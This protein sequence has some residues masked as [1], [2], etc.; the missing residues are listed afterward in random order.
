[1]SNERALGRRSSGLLLLKQR[2]ESC[3]QFFLQED[4]RVLGLKGHST[5]SSS[6]CSCLRSSAL[7]DLTSSSAR[8]ASQ[9]TGME[10]KEKYVG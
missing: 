10:N 6:S 3:A 4:E 2:E 8:T 1:M 5:R 7:D 9:F